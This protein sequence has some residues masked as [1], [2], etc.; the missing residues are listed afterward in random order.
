MPA[1][2]FKNIP[3]HD[4]YIFP[5]ALPQSLESDQKQ[6][7]NPHGP[8]PN[9]FTFTLRDGPSSEPTKGG[10]VQI[11]DSHNFKVAETVAAALVTVHPGGMR[12]MHWHPNADEWQYY[13][14]GEARMGVFNTGPKAVT[15]DFHPGDI[16]YVKRNLGH[17]I[18]NTGTED[19]VFLEVFRSDT[20]QEVLLSDWLTHTPTQMVAALLNVP[21]DTIAKWPNGNAPV[22]PV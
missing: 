5:S 9:P 13:I 18:K 17:Y 1:D 12:A 8:P 7:E 22:V 2:T 10:F 6:M 11:V 4:L 16:G 14:E 20:Y 3:L 15:M 21:A 19:L